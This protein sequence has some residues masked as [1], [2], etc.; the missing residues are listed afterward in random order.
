MYSL[1]PDHTTAALV[2]E[3]ERNDHFIHSV[4]F[5]P[6]GEYIY[7]TETGKTSTN[8]YTMGSLRRAELVCKLPQDQ[9]RGL[10]ET[11]NQP[12]LWSNEKEQVDG[13]AD[14]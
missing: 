3:V 4:D 6:A 11:P 14:R 2:D 9:V 8:K 7:W 10:V 1:G 13:S 5:S 12:E